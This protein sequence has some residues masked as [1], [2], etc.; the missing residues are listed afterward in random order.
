MATIDELRVAVVGASSVPAREIVDV[1]RSRGFPAREVTLLGSDETAGRTLEIEGSERRRR[2]PRSGGRSPASTSPSSRRDRR[3]RARGRRWRSTRARRSS[4]GRA[5]TVSTPDVPLVVPEVNRDAIAEHRQR[6]IVSSPSATTIGL[7]VVLAPLHEAAGLRRGD[8]VDLPGRRQRGPP[9]VERALARDHRAAQ[10]PQSDEG[11]L[12]AAA[13]VQQRAAGGCARAGRQ[14]DAR[15]AR[16]G[17]AAA[18][19]RRAR[20]RRPRDGGARADLLRLGDERRRRDRVAARRRGARGSCCARRR[21]CS[22]T[23]PRTT[24][25]RPQHEI[26][27]SEAT[28]V[29]RLRDDPSAEHALSLWITLDSLRKGAALNA[30]QIAEILRRASYAVG[31]GRGAATASS[32]ST[33]APTTRAGSCSPA[34]RRC[35]ASS[36]RRSRPRCASPSG[37]RAAGRTDAGVHATGQVAAAPVSRVPEDLDRL[38]RSLNALTPDDLA[39]RA[40]DVVDDAFDPRR[41]AR[42]R[43]YVYRLWNRASRLAVLA[44]LG[45]A[46]PAAARPRRRCGRRRRRWSA[47]TTSPPSRA[48]DAEPMRSTVRRALLSELVEDGPMLVYEIEAT[49]F[50]RHMVRN[51][52]GTLVE[53]GRGD[54]AGRLD[55]G[56]DRRPRPHAR[57]R[58]RTATRPRADRRPLLVCSDRAFARRLFATRL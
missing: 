38:R 15:A 1:L 14:H 49:A 28:H 43:V 56:A 21:A 42:S 47:S 10:L 11:P 50:L 12:R 6:G 19:A 54:R 13:R 2:A 32:S 22:C 27:G 48:P 5:A 25:T 23:P 18:R 37:S 58:H 7:A 41:H 39:I 51:I 46:P 52:V 45:V 35:R 31:D 44:P 33:T 26:V 34:G 3:S 9:R 55:R 30:V 20:P 29:G 4:T 17:G 36:S 57:G 8:G 53:V 24:P 16:R 40:V